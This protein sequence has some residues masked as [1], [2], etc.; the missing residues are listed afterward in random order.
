MKAV[1]R[2]LATRFLYREE[3]AGRRRML[4]PVVRISIFGIGLGVMLILLSFF[5]VQGFKRDIQSKINGFSGT[6]RISNPENI[7]DR[8]S[9]P[10]S[11]SEGLMEEIQSVSVEVDP[12]ART[13]VFIQEMGLIKVDSAFKTV[14][15]QGL[16]GDYDTKFYGSFLKEGHLPNF[17]GELFNEVLI[18]NALSKYLNI[19]PGDEFL[20]YFM[21]DGGIK[22][23]KYKISGLF[24]T[25]FDAYDRNMVIADLRSLRSIKNWAENEVSGISITLDDSKQA[26]VLYERLFPL[27]ADRNAE[28]GERYSMFTVEE[29]NFNIFGWL[30]LLDANVILILGL[31]IAVAGMTIITGIV[32]LILEK[33]RAIAT[34]KAMGQRNCSLRMVFTLM[35]SAILVRGFLWGNICA[36]ILAFVQKI[37]K[38]ISL[39]PS[40]YYMTHVPIE[41]NLNLILLINLIVFLSVFIFILIPTSI[42][43]NIKPSDSLR[44]E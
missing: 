30:K 39:D 10:L 9:L 44:F 43:A 28:R 38:P 41:I 13:N 29:L 17:S 24:E 20:C 21:N 16:D 31:M 42:I 19:F 34:L 25:G 6:L 12:S 40:Q 23:R 14:V 3:E 11:L 2:I 33:V 32:V 8:Y 15:F 27:L 35:A 1:E 5:I 22:M 36:L 37:W 4:R 7:Y 18:S 26:G